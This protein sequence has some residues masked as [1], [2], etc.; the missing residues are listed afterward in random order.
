MT[1][2]RAL[3]R[4]ERAE[5]AA[6]LA[7][8]T[9]E[10]WDAPTLCTAWRVRDVVAH[11]IG[12]DLEGMT[13]FARTLVR[14][15]FSPDGANQRVVEDLRDLDPRGLLDLV[16]RYETPAGLPSAARSACRGR[17]RRSGCGRSSTS[18]WSPSRSGRSCGPAA[19]VSS[20]PTWT[21]RRG[22]ARRS[23][24]PPRRC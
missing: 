14:S 20:R 23:T 1:D 18:R 2:T 5:F 8:L 11:V 21:G 4:E 7:T 12:Y 3:A 17:S 24:G 9:P 10:Q 19:C 16:R 13:G 6:F 22:V 15:G